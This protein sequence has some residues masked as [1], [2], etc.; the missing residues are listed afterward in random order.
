MFKVASK[1]NSDME[2]ILSYVIYY[3]N[4]LHTF[5]FEESKEL[6][7]HINIK[8]LKVFQFFSK[9]RRSKFVRDGLA[10]EQ[11]TEYADD[12]IRNFHNKKTR[13]RRSYVVSNSN[14]V[15][16]EGIEMPNYEPI[17]LTKN[18]CE[19]SE[20]L[21]SLCSKGPLFIPAPNTFD[22]RQLQIDFDKFK[23]TLR[24]ISFFSTI[25][26]GSNTSKNTTL[27]LAIDNPPLKQSLWI[28]PKSNSNEIET[29]ISLVEKD[30]FQGTSRKR[31]PSNLS[32]DEKKAL[33]I[34]K[35]YIYII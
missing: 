26:A 29:F 12:F 24:K 14:K 5:Y 4:Y 11:A 27:P 2:I 9:V 22:W 34:L 13:T 16:A 25:E 8:Q 6:L 19:L 15:I 35:I 1:Y 21:I 32:E 28:P 30:L 7:D 31:I 20:G 10:V 3:K 18:N 33:K 17:N 23:N